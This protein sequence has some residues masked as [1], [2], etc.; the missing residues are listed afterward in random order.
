[1]SKCGVVYGDS[2]PVDASQTN[3]GEHGT[4]LCTQGDEECGRL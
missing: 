4:R 3:C 2:M 1:M